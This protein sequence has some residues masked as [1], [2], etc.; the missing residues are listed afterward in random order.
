MLPGGNFPS[1]AV[2]M[3]RS[4]LGIV[5]GWFMGALAAFA[6]QLPALLL[7]PL[8][9]AVRLDDRAALAQHISKLPAA[10]FVAIALAWAVAPFVAAFVAALI[11]RRRLFGHALALGLVFL[12]MDAINLWSIPSPWWLN[13][14]GILL[15]IP[16]AILGA[17]I[18]G[19]FLPPSPATVPRYDMRERNMAC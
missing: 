11:V 2:S 3:F 5:V 19:R 7:W 10:A 4:V 1:E 16:A 15:P 14:A 12:A 18:A 6:V 9:P 8:P 17:M 13:A